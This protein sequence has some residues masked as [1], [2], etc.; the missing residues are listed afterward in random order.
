MGVSYWIILTG[1]A[2][3]RFWKE[4]NVDAAG[5]DVVL[6]VLPRLVPGVCPTI[7]CAVTAA[8]T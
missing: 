2:C 5:F 3:L 4:K 8:A 7:A 6:P 1:T